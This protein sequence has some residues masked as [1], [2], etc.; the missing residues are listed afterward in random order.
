MKALEIHDIASLT[1]YAI[2]SGLIS[3]RKL[4]PWPATL[5]ALFA[6]LARAFSLPIP[7]FSLAACRASIAETGSPLCVAQRIDLE[8]DQDGRQATRMRPEQDV[9]ERQQAEQILRAHE[10]GLRRSQQ[11]GRLAYVIT[12]P[13]GEFLAWSETLPAMIGRDAAAIPATTRGWLDL[14]HLE[15]REGFRRTA[16]EAA[17][18]GERAELEYRLQHGAGAWV[19]IRE[20]MEPLDPEPGA[21]ATRRWLSTLQDISAAK[22]TERAL[23]LSAEH[24]GATFEDAAVGI[25]HT[26]LMGKVRLVNQ[27]FCAMTGYSRD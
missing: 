21:G 25:A 26:S 23:Q 14:L 15:D 16:I 9:T 6:R 19:H 17:K 1:R 5:D 10:A 8:C 18:S 2:R 13:A 3:P 11:M 22:R 7:G 27:A 20:V 24:Y 4:N 12:G